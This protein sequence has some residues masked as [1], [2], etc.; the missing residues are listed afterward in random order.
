MPNT[1]GPWRIGLAQTVN[2]G[3]GWTV[4]DILDS[5][6]AC[7]MDTR[8]YSDENRDADVRLIS[9]APDLLAALKCV[10]NLPGFEPDEEY[11]EIVLAAI[12]KAEGKD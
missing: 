11:G 1:P 6:G 12:R 2:G 8:H 10:S 9:A 3:R 7:F 5:S 4:V